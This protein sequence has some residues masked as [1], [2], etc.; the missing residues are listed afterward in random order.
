MNI[1]AIHVPLDTET[2]LFHPPSADG[3][4]FRELKAFK[5]TEWSDLDDADADANVSSR[6]DSS[7]PEAALFPVLSYSTE[8]IVSLQYLQALFQAEPSVQNLLALITTQYPLNQKQQLII[9][10]L[11]LRILYPVRISSVRD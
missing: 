3:T 5:N 6:F 1:A 4:W 2:N 11:I 10:A 7:W 9:T 8:S